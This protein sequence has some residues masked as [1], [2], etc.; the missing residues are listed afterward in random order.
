MGRPKRKRTYGSGQIVEPRTAGGVWGIRWREGERR[1]YVG[2]LATRELAERMLAHLAGQLAAGRT[3]LPAVTRDVATLGEHSTRFLERREH[4]H[5]GGTEDG[6]RW[7]KHL[8]PHFNH[9]KPGD[10]DAARIRLYVET[11]LREGLENGTVRGHVAL[12]SSL[13][14][15][16]VEQGFATANPARSLPRATRRLLKPSHDPRTTP[17]IEKLDDVRRLFLELP[18]PLNIAYAIGAL[19]GL[20]TGE[21]FALKWA[22]VDLDARRI[23]VREQVSG[24]LKD[25]D[26]RVV[27]LLDGL[28]PVLA[29]WKLQTGGDGLVVPPM[30]RDGRHINKSTPGGHLEAALVKLK[31]QREGLGW[32]ECTRHTFASQW[33]L[34]GGSIFQL[35]EILGHY[36]VTETERY[37]HLNPKLFAQKD[38]GTIPLKLGGKPAQPA[39]IGQQLGST[40]PK[41]ARK[42]R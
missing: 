22:H 30:R 37:A 17:F 9:L 11:K 20:R 40:T 36:S 10:V 7:R 3:G 1:R 6:Y 13:F 31:L 8:A 26:S 12:L 41:R 39:D 23:H 15:D 5:R 4:T 32:Y 19:G 29:K 21:V 35:K 18:K 2:G 16:L 14:V 34:A 24:P 42:V 38:L 33:V 28:Y 27:P 25:S